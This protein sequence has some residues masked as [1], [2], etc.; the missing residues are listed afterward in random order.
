MAEKKERIKLTTPVFRVS[1]PQLFEAKAYGDS[2]EK[3]SVSAIVRKDVTG[4]DRELLQAMYK[5][6]E[7]LAIEKFGEE[8]FKKMRKLNQFKWPF[9]DGE[10]K[11]MQGY[12][13]EV[14][15]FSLS[16]KLAPGVIGR[17]KEPLTE[18]DVYAGCYARATVSPYHFDNKSKGIAFGL[19]NL[20]KVGEGEAFSQR[21]TAEEDFDEA[22]DNVWKDD[23]VA[24]I[25]GG[26]EGADDNMFT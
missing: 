26:S 18:K 3:F 16:T 23:Y 6:A 19:N 17:N 13:P 7:K 24:D 12:G 21:T 15:F 25:P 5:A 9:R 10:E 22:D 8:A 14:I 20:Q 2:E 1:F 4:K 11:D